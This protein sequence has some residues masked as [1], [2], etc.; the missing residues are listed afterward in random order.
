[1]DQT[2]AINALLDERAI[3]QL[4]V[5]YSA[6]IDAKDFAALRDIFTPDAQIDYESAG[7]ASGNL[8]EIIT[9]LG[10][11]LE[12]FS[13]VQHMVSNFVIQIDGDRAKSSCY[14]HNPMGMPR[15]DGKTHV[16]WCG[17]RYR[18]ELV[19]TPEGWRIA[20]R[21]NDTLYMHGA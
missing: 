16:F 10:Q 12:P 17:G 8:E 11:A 3:E 9:W 20:A 7:G 4:L 13:L 1:M 21:I 15:E 18:D 5:R 19:R 2:E 6:V 14:F